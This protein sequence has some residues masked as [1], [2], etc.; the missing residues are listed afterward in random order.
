[1][2]ISCSTSPSAITLVASESTCM[3]RM[4]FTSTI[5]WKAREYRK[6]PTSTLA[7]LPNRSLAVSRPRR[8][9][10]SSTTS[11]CSSV[12]VWMNSTTAA[13]VCRCG[14]WLPDGA[15][16]HQQQGRTQALAPGRN[17]VLRHLPD[18]RHFGGQPFAGSPRSTRAM[19]GWIR[20]SGLPGLGVGVVK[21]RAGKGVMA[22][23]AGPCA[24]IESEPMPLGASGTAG[25]V[26]PGVAG[27]CPCSTGS[28]RMLN[29]RA[30]RNSVRW[31]SIRGIFTRGS[32]VRGHK[33]R[34]Q[35]VSCCCWRKN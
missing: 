22:E 2:F 32:Y 13:S 10:D 11:S 23:D 29:S 7:A 4:S 17:D 16:Q 18:Q 3:T 15:A 27:A 6:S 35:T 19:S 25:C 14:L 31:I 9:V 21:I 34:W 5:I 33:N 26:W 24:I 28:M 30:R 1:M 12:A 20:S 8:R